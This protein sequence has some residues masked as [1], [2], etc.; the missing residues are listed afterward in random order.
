MASA[1]QPDARP[2]WLKDFFPGYF[3]LVMATGVVAMAAHTLRYL[4]LSWLLFA[5]ALAAYPALWGILLARMV[6][7]PRAIV[8]DFVSHERGPTF[9]TIVA[10]NGVLGGQFAL[11]HVLTALL[12][13]LFWF[14]LGLWTVLVYGFLSAVTARIAKP[15]LEHG[16][17][18]SWL[19]LV[20]ATEA[21]SVLASL[22]ALQYGASQALVF[23]ALAFY[24]LGAMLYVL[25]SALIFFR[26]VFRP[27]HPVEMGAPWWINMGAVAIA[28]L[29]GSQLMGLALSDDEL[30]PFAH[31]IVSFTLLLWVTS[32]FWIPLLV[33]LFAW[34]EM[35]RGPRG[36]DPGLW[37]AVFPLG[38][39][40]VATH[41]YAAVAGF[42]FLEPLPQVAFWIALVTW[43]LS[44]IGMVTQLL[45]FGKAPAP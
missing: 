27:M 42:T 5:V 8:A 4:A 34:K 24:L 31:F 39:Y 21:L 18:G 23:A 17:N 16:L 11:F 22:L 25:L 2:A 1:S 19:M 12:P 30:A 33:I 32:S 3:A 44:F 29:A 20:V 35:Q 6:C 37:S 28:T 45:G 14:S 10:A 43:V 40:T 15:D 7:F 41:D 13:A 36:Y 38:M 9:L 26:W